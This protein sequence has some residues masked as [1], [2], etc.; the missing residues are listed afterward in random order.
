MP[1]TTDPSQYGQQDITGE[2]KR[3][4]RRQEPEQR[5]VVVWLQN[6]DAV[7]NVGEKIAMGQRHRLGS[8]L[9]A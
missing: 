9:G 2:P 6:I 3:M 1:H 4:K 7:E 8:A 5:V